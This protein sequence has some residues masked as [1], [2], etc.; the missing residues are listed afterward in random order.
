MSPLKKGQKLT[1]NP[2]DKL[3]QVRVD[4]ET[5]EKLDCIVAKTGL[6]RSEIVRNGIEQEYQNVTNQ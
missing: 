5:L 2:K 4:A 3:L 1:D 6:K